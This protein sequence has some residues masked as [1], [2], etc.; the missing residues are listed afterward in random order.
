MELVRNQIDAAIAAGQRPRQVAGGRTVLATGQ[1][2]GGR[3]RQYKVLADASGKLSK[4]GEYYYNEATQNEVKPNATFD[5]NQPTIR[6]GDSDWIR[7]KS[8]LQKVRQFNANGTMTVTTLGQAYYAN[9]HTE[10]I[11]KIPVIIEV[12]NSKGQ[13][14]VRGGPGREPE[15][16]PSEEAG[17][18][19]ILQSQ[20]L[21][22]QQQIERVKADV[23]AQVGGGRTVNGRL[24]LIKISEQY[25]YY[26]P[27]GEWLISAQQTT[28]DAEGNPLTQV[29]LNEP[30]D[31]GDPLRGLSSAA[32]L[33]HE[34]EFYLD[35]AFELH[36]DAYCVPRQLAVLLNKSLNAMCESFDEILA[37]GW[38]SEGVRPQEL[39]QWCALHGH[40]YMLVRSGRL[41]KLVEPP[42]K[43]GRCIA[44]E[45]Y[46]GHAFFFKTAR[47]IS[48]WS[49]S[50][51][52]AVCQEVV[53]KDP[54][55]SRPPIEEWGVFDD[56]P[57]PGYWFASD[58]SAARKSMLESG[59]SPK[60]QL[61]KG[62]KL[63][64]L[65]YMCTKAR[66]GCTGKCVV[67]QAIGNFEL[68]KEWLSR[69]PRKIDWCGE[70]LPALTQ[71][72]LL[73]LLRAERRNCP[74][75]LRRSILEAQ[76]HNCCTCG[77]AFD[78]DIEWDHVAPLQQ[79]C[80]G[81]QVQ[82]QAICASCHLEKT[83]QEGRQDRTIESRFSLP[84]YRA[85]VDSPRP[86]QLAFRP[87][88]WGKQEEE[89]LEIDC[90]R[91]R[92][93]GLVHASHD[94][95]VFCPLDSVAPAVAGELADFSFVDLGKDDRRSVVS[96]L[97]YVGPMWMHRVSV[98]FMLHHGAC[99]W[100]DI[101]YSL[102]ATGKVPKECIAAPLEVMEA[103]WGDHID[104]AK[105]SVNAMLGLWAVD[106][107]QSFHVKSSNDPFEG[108]GAWATRLV[109]WNG[110][111]MTD[112]IFA[113]KLLTNASMRPVHDMI[114]AHEHT[115]IASILFCLSSLKIPQ[116]CIKDINTDCV[117]VKG[118]AK[119]HK[120]A[121]M[122][123]AKLTFKDLPNLRRRFTEPKQ[124]FLDAR[125]DTPNASTEECFRVRP[126]KP[127]E[128]YFAEPRR[129]ARRPEPRG[130][131]WDLNE[132]EAL[133]CVREGRN[134]L[135]LGP[136]G[137]GKSYWLRQRVAELR[138]AGHHTMVIAK[139]HLACQN[140][141]CE[142]VT[143]DHFCY[144][145]IRNGSSSCHT[146]CVEEAGMVN[147]Q[148]WADVAQLRFKGT[149]F[150]L[151]AD[152]KQFAPVCEHWLANRVKKGQLAASDML[153]EMAGG[154]RFTLTENMRSDAV[155]FKFYT[156]LDEVNSLEAELE[157][158][159]GLFPKT[160]RKAAYTLTM[161]HA[162]RV[163][164]NGRRNR[165]EKPEDA[166]LLR[167]PPTTGRSGGNEAQDMYIWVGL[168][169]IGAGKRTKKGLFY[170]I[171][172]IDET[173]VTFTCGLKLSREKCVEC[174]RLSYAVTF[175]SSQGLTLQGV[176]RLECDSMYMTM[177]HLY[178][179]ISRATSHTLVEVCC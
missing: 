23:L 20:S 17:V 155:L 177:T 14:R 75:E 30:L 4:A 9:K 125:V 71:K 112:W 93:N 168:T 53:D 67:K 138:A 95:P 132:Q 76:G 27:D 169:L 99:K 3:A 150:V 124:G 97:P 56:T 135:I 147:V 82:W 134:L 70:G 160:S 8:G 10:F 129:E 107:Q 113:K 144:K 161:S 118:F 115:L 109:E 35:E 74:A 5:P 29:V 139:T 121:I 21:S 157:R 66:D 166:V 131:W 140:I 179:G 58:L 6:R 158:A 89:V 40:P 62:A 61:H 39:K 64:S 36:N 26:W 49:V 173:T 127:L 78:D 1:G 77:G 98:E 12:T 37:E 48:K 18:G 46:D 100:D 136:P 59:R 69:L 101:K 103:A 32:F 151:A 19:R 102:N 72:V 162:R 79:L 105:D 152:F 34:P 153:Y 45:I 54:K 174:C 141:G 175:A 120:A 13:T 43:M 156:S 163:A 41:V 63:S 90:R 143:A 117:E 116:H 22:P 25:Y 165:E 88:D 106:E 178:V 73:E 2:E 81:Q 42:C 149:S 128:G 96:K 133:E 7:T 92:R 137:V 52:G 47:T 68:I 167:A 84:V 126:G 130:Q 171:A 122:D 80:Q 108:Q 11:V 91:C 50:K 60:V 24:F 159:K 16:L 145:Y 154:H 94:F 85:Y 111:H 31:H 164:V 104:M 148:I 65:S 123:L 57:Q 114:M 176:V 51:P 119:K 172:E 28:V 33:S 146:L 170:T 15:H 142:A 44:Y 83:T 55:N 86:P 110:G 87:R 38:R